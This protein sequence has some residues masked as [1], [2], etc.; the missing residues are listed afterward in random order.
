MD[1]ASQVLLVFVVT[2]CIKY[3]LE[4]YRRV[5]KG[6]VRLVVFFFSSFLF[7]FFLLLFF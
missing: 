4:Y 1:L 7:Y 5:N 2:I 3:F 6:N